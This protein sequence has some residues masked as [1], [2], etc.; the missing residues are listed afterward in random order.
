[1]SLTQN[2]ADFAEAVADEFNKRP[3]NLDS[4]NVPENPQDKQFWR[5]RS[6]GQLMQYSIFTG[7]FEPVT[8][9]IATDR[10]LDGG[11]F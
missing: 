9:Y 10:P 11:N 5:R 6:D 7:Q 8:A 3:P 2:I 4:E 1:M